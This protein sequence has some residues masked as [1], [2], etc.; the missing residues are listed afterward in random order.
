MTAS[1]SSPRLTEPRVPRWQRPPSFRLVGGALREVPRVRRVS[2]IP[3]PA[4]GASARLLRPLRRSPKPLVK[5]RDT[6]G[7]LPANV[8]RALVDALAI[9]LVAEYRLQHLPAQ[10]TR[11]DRTDT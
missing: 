8:F 2:L 11:L 4:L 6:T 7:A 10:S 9:A 3:R 1:P 5:R